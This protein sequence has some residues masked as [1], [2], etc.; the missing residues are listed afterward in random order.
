MQIPRRRTAARLLVTLL[1]ALVLVG[2]VGSAD[3]A[4]AATG[5]GAATC[6]RPGARDDDSIHIQGCLADS[7]EKPPTPVSDVAITIDDE[8]GKAVAEGTSDASGVF[9]IALPGKSIDVLGNTYTV[10]IDSDTLPDGADLRNPD[11][12]SLKVRLRL[13]SDVFV[14][15]PI[16]DDSTSATGKLK[17]GLQLAA[18]GLV[19]SSLLAMAAVGL[20]MIFGTTGLTNFAH[21]ELI[22]FG[23]MVAFAVDKL[24]GNIVLLGFNIT[25]ATGIIA[26]VVLS[27]G[28]GWSQDKVLWKPLRRRGTGLIA[29]MI[30]SIGLS[31]F[32]RNVYQY[33]AGA[34]SHNYSQW[35]SP[36]PWK[37]GPVLI[38]PKDV[39][40]L[41]L[42]VVVLTLVIFAVQRTR[43]GKAT[44][45]V[46]DNPA[47]A[48]SSGINVDRVISVVWMVGAALAGLSGVLLGMTQ[49]FDYQ[50][51]F[52]IL[53]LV[54]AAVVLGGLGSITGA[55]IGSFVIGIFIEVSTLFIPAELKFVGAL[56]VLIVVLLVRPQGLLGRA[57]RV[58]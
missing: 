22:T 45:A 10:K 28:F 17:Q 33:F 32:L 8:S 18:G 37:I 57:E 5:A 12:K 26:A 21:G 3:T 19:F 25:M 39:G 11:Q 49:G 15:F 16:G 56:V 31:V 1:G 41:V 46:A 43:L 52:K 51:G 55:L 27:A 50:L 35:S 42:A 48:S 30:V 13:D 7:R 14:T 38:T 34:G 6:E 54:F 47:L 9:D 53:L 44:R 36:Q 2:V 58:G 29:A 20:S 24:P 23:A 4:S 40:V